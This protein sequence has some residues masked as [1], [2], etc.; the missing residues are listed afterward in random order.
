MLLGSFD[1][2]QKL[3]KSKARVQPEIVRQERLNRQMLILMT[4]SIL[5]F[6]ATTLPVNVRR[7]IAAYQMINAGG[8]SLQS[9]VIGTGSFTVLL[10][11]NYGVSSVNR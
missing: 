2:Y 11:L 10:T 8:S 9:I 7:I 1:I 3:K 4:T 6:F 5:I